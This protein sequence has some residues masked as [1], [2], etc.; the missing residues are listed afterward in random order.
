MDRERHM[1]RKAPAA[2]VWCG[3]LC[4]A[5]LLQFGPPGARNGVE[6]FLTQSA[7]TVLALVDQV[8][9][10]RGVPPPPDGHDRSQL[11]R[12]AAENRR[13]SLQVAQLQEQLHRLSTSGDLSPFSETSPATESAAGNRSLLETQSLVARV[14]GRQSSPVSG[15]LRLLVRLGEKAGL[16]GDELVLGHAGVLIDRGARAALQRDQLVWADRGLFGRTVAVGRWTTTV[17]PVTH[18]EF[19]IGVRIVRRSPRGTVFGSRGILAGTGEG[20]RLLEVP[21]TEPVV[22]GDFV[23]TDAALTPGAEAIYCGR[24]TQAT[25]GPNDGQW[26][27]EVAPL[28]HPVD[29]PREL[30]VLRAQ[31]RLSGQ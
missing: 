16:V 13:L 26:T 4:C 12:L 31:L 28:H 11:E 27:I 18:P 10:S 17:Q 19:R 6:S 20:C 5:L 23:Y 22:E 7:G 25:V 9:G 29:I 24:V 3:W 2:A 8:I 1:P 15:D 21:A 30:H 14:L